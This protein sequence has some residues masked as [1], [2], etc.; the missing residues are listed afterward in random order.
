MEPQRRQYPIPENPCAAG[1]LVFKAFLG[2][3]VPGLALSSWLPV[4]RSRAELSSTGTLFH[5]IPWP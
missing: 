1:T 5:L 4:P 3:L 2:P